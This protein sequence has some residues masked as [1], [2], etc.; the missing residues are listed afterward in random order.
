MQV[1]GGKLMR[2]DAMS[3]NA[4]PYFDSGSLTAALM[5][6]V[7][8]SDEATALANSPAL[9]FNDDES[10]VLINSSND[11]WYYDKSSRAM[12]RLTNNKDEEKEADFSPDG[13]LVSFVRG[14]NLFVVDVAKANE[15]QLT[16]DGREGDKQIFNGYLDWVYEEEL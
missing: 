1:V 2:V 9:Q 16:R 5:R 6:I 15:K 11:L 7:L 10:D 13:R 8:K 12:R 14:N 4:V 3:G